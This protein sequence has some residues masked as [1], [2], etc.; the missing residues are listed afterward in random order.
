VTS[1]PLSFFTID[2]GTAATGVA[3]VA[4]IDGR[5]RLLASDVAPSEIAVDALLE[6]LVARTVST[7]PS[8]L[9][10]PEGWR[11]WAR[12]ESATS[13][14]LGVVLAAPSDAKVAELRQAFAEAGWNIRATAVAGHVDMRALAEA[15]I[16]PQ[17]RAI[18]IAP[19]G[20]GAVDAGG[21]AVLASL[22]AAMATSRSDVNV[23]LCGTEQ[24][25]PAGF[26]EGRTAS[27]PAPAAVP[28]GLPSHL[29]SAAVDLAD[30][31]RA[32][33]HAGTGP[34]IPDGR[35]AFG[36]SIGT[37]CRLLDRRVE[38]V[39]V[40][41]SS[42]TRV[43]AHPDGATWITTIADG[44]LVPADAIRDDAEVE[45]I[46]GW[47]ALRVDPFSLMDRIRNLRLTPWRE[48]SD[49]GARLRLGALRAALSRLDAAWGGKQRGVTRDAPAPGELLICAGGTFSVLPAP[50]AALALVDT[51]RRPGALTIFH[52]HARMLG[53][54]GTLADE[55]DRRRLLADLLD[56][57]LVPIGSAIVTGE[58]KSSRHPGH[59][60]LVSTI[61]QGEVE[62]APG[63]LRLLDLPPGVAARLELDSKDGALLG[64]KAKRLAL[65]VTGGLAGLLLDTR[66]VPLKIPDRAERRRAVFEDWERPIWAS[67]EP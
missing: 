24:G 17:V 52:D 23:L 36:I 50:A 65:E 49:D 22:L 2:H 34:V 11:D 64:L 30:R 35:R 20:T 18:A 41:H 39:D 62:L 14:P 21:M 55:P 60:K 3:L 32:D 58:I 31:L 27:A 5:F 57:L 42:G 19:A 56:D 33:A 25:A 54:I 1:A 43:L 8:V 12:L 9:P 48:T 10:N 16:D 28:R 29:R 26:P 45:Q 51:L 7:D 37:L 40:G 59:L 46:L 6:D 13:E 38:A 61:G 53:P 67:V 44:A 4:P 15:C 47:S 66:E 63:T